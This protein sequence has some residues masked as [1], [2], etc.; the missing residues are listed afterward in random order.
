[1]SLVFGREKAIG[2]VCKE[3]FPYRLELYGTL[4]II[5]N[6]YEVSTVF[7]FAKS[8]RGCACWFLLL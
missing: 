1:M 3:L 6:L 5:C 2:F 8:R 7:E 4:G